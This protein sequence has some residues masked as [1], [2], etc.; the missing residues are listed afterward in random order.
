[1]LNLRLLNLAVEGQVRSLLDSLVRP[2]VLVAQLWQLSRVL[3]DTV[4]VV[5]S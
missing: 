5:L 3:D 4:D 1:M 2:Y